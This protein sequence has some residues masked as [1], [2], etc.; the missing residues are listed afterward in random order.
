MWLQEAVKREVEE[1]S[2][3]QFEPETLTS[4]EA[5]AAQMWYRFTFTGIVT[6][7]APPQLVAAI[8]HEQYSNLSNVYYV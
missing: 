8:V 4:V 6:G 1:E 5:S 2:G 7:N 3:L